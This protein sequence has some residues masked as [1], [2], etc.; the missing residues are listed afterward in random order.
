MTERMEQL[1]GRL[2]LLSDPSGTT[3]R[4]VIPAAEC[5]PGFAKSA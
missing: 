3:V 4:A 2:E 5:S 1:G